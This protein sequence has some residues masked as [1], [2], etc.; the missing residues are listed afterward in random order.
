MTINNRISTAILFGIIGVIIIE[1]V[2]VFLFVKT[3]FYFCIVNEVNDRIIALGNGWQENAEQ[4]GSR[5][6]LISYTLLIL[7]FAYI[8]RIV[9]SN[10]C[11]SIGFSS[12]MLTCVVVHLSRE[13]LLY[14]QFS[15][16]FCKIKLSL[17]K[18]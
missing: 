1:T 7:L 8:T 5:N 11:S 16:L 4:N 3:Y 14:L 9:I 6:S 2:H 18:I 10:R 12:F 13:R 15:F 17:I